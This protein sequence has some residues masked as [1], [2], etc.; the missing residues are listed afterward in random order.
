MSLRKR[1]VIGWLLV[2]VWG[3]AGWAAEV[4]EESTIRVFRLKGMDAQA[5]AS[6]LYEIF[7]PIPKSDKPTPRFVA[8]RFGNA[9]IVVAPP[10][11]LS[12]V[13]HLVNQLDVPLKPADTTVRF[14]LTVLRVKASAAAMS[15]LS[16]SELERAA[17][18]VE[19]LRER[20]AE[21]GEAVVH[22]RLHQFVDLNSEAEIKMFARVPF[23]R[24]VSRGE[25]G[26]VFTGVE[27]EDMGLKVSVMELD[28][29]NDAKARA[30]F[31]VEMS[32]M[33]KSPVEL[34]QG[35]YAPVFHVHKHHFDGAFEPGRPFILF[36]AEPAHEE[37]EM[38]MAWITR[39][40]LTP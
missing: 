9:L 33:S 17:E 12:T 35:Q 36:H 4:A 32:A 23:V 18:T 11:V 25:S 31:T 6:R 3:A 21:V 13:E 8:D 10:S 1:V 19:G 34:G 5:M 29:A 16:V 15:K 27:Y 20:I 24:T 37:P 2:C 14:D 39:V 28:S 40:V 26:Q 7:P 30:S 38:S 22:Y